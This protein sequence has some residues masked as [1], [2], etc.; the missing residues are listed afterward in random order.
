MSNYLISKER[1]NVVSSIFKTLGRDGCE[2]FIR[3]DPQY[4][5]LS[6]LPSLCGVI[7]IKLVAI[8]SLVSYMLSVRGEEFWGLFADFAISRCGKVR[9]FKEA[10][11][12]VKEFTHNYN[13]LYLEAKIRRLSK[14]LRCGNAFNSLEK[15]YI[16]EY[17]SKLSSCLEVEENSKT[18]V[19]SA[20]MAYY[21]LKSIGVHADL[22][23]IPIPVDRRV[24]L[25]TLTSGLLIPPKKTKEAS[26]RLEDLVTELL[27]HPEIVRKVWDVVSEESGIPALLI[28]APIWLI[29]GYV[30]TSGTDE[31]V[32]NLRSLG[33]LISESLLTR[34]VSELT[35][36]LREGLLSL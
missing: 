26:G 1:I 32:K 24:A 14:V 16:K 20:K 9:D 27:K 7:S 29:G 28:D 12:A 18:L 4:V 21:V 6:K 23:K 11:E 33:I 19:F 35:L 17:L 30:K 15:G 8:N 2:E 25:V 5:A 22:S 10:V 13:K 34:L 3:I 31:I 36:A